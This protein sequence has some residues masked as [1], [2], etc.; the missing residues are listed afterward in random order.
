MNIG[1]FHLRNVSLM[2][3]V[4]AEKDGLSITSAEPLAEKASPLT[5]LLVLVLAK[6]LNTTIP[7]I[8]TRPPVSLLVTPV[9][10]CPTVLLELPSTSTL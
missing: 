3:D 8:G 10:Q 4:T 7:E 1:K 2:R 5:K 9:N 6:T